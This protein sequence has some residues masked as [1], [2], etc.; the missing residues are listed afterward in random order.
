MKI[1]NKGEVF[2]RSAG[3]DKGGA[4]GKALILIFFD[5]PT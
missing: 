1:N 4:I 3:F 2:N 5:K